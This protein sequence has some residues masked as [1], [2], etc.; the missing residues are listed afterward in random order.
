MLI[1]GFTEEND[2]V[3]DLGGSGSILLVIKQIEVAFALN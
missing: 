3:V 2:T 1:N